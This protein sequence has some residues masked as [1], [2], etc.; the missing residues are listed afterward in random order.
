MLQA[1]HDV[2]LSFEVVQT[3]VYATLSFEFLHGHSL[4]FLIQIFLV[5]QESLVYF[6]I[7]PVSYATW[8]ENNREDYYY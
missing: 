2:H 3:R 5:L 6:T 8:G 1:L 7:E 4:S